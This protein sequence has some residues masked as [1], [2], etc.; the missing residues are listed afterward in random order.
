M[1]FTELVELGGV[2]CWVA[3][4]WRKISS[5]GGAAEVGCSDLLI[6]G[7]RTDIEKKDL[8]QEN[9]AVLSIGQ[10][11]YSCYVGRKW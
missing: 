6:I 3:G 4:W 5:Y 1:E 2:Y 9:L 10:K 11:F 7:D 8:G